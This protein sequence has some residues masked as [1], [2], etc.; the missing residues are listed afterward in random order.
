M[1]EKLKDFNKVQLEKAAAG[2]GVITSDRLVFLNE[3]PSVP[4]YAESL[5]DGLIEDEI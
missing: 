4:V 3:L 2:E 5:P 1:F